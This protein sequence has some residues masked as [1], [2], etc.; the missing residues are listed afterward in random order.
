MRLRAA[1]PR[2]RSRFRFGERFGWIYFSTK[3]AAQ[4]V[5]F[6]PDGDR[7]PR[8]NRPRE[9]IVHHF[10]RAGWSPLLLKNTKL[11]LGVACLVRSRGYSIHGDQGPDWPDSSSGWPV[12]TPQN[13]TVITPRLHVGN[14]RSRATAGVR[15]YDAKSCRLAGAIAALSSMLFSVYSGCAASL[16]VECGPVR[17]GLGAGPAARWS[18]MAFPYNWAAPRFPNISS[19]QGDTGSIWGWALMAGLGPAPADSSGALSHKINAATITPSALRPLAR[20]SSPIS[21]A[22]HSAGRRGSKF[23]LHNTFTKA[24][25]VGRKS[26][27][28]PPTRRTAMTFIIIWRRLGHGCHRLYWPKRTMALTTLPTRERWLGGG[29]NGARKPRRQSA[30]TNFYLRA[31]RVL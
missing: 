17:E 1:K 14:E 6:G 10:R 2:G 29:N 18:R 5:F 28:A 27:G 24:V 15:V 31:P 3:G 23:I 26:F 12:W 22:A 11:G 8:Q 13:H 25:A 21:P 19:T 20:C 16:H 4:S 7:T 9:A 30:R